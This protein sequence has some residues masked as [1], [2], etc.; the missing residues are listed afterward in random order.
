MYLRNSNCRVIE[1]TPQGHSAN[2][3][4]GSLFSISNGPVYICYKKGKD[5]PPIVDIG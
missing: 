4:V 5:K 3:T 2:L 1:T